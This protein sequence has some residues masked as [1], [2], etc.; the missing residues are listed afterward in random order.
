MTTKGTG[1][2]LIEEVVRE[3]RS[4]ARLLPTIDLSLFLDTVDSLTKEELALFVSDFKGQ[5][6][7]NW[8]RV[9]INFLGWCAETGAA[10]S[11]VARDLQLPKVIPV[12]P[13]IMD[14]ETFADLLTKAY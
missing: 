9:L 13:A 4:I 1:Q 10:P 12:R 6:A 7:V 8:R 3:T 2:L 14:S 11:N 5:N